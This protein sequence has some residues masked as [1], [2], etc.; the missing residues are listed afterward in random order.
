[1]CVIALAHVPRRSL[2][3]GSFDGRVPLGRIGGSRQRRR[4]YRPCT[5]V[6]ADHG[7]TGRMNVRE[8]TLDDAGAIRDVAQRSMEASYSL[9]PRTIQSAIKQW[10]ND[11]ALEETFGTDGVVFLVAEEDG[12]VVGF[13]E[14]VLDDTGNGDLLWLHVDPSVRGAGV[15]TQLFERMRTDLEER[16]AERLRG[17]VLEDNREGTDFFERFG[18]E[19]AEERRV[20][21]DGEPYVEFV[22]LEADARPDE[23][24]LDED[25]SVPK[26]VTTPDGR[27]VYLDREDPDRG[28]KGPF[29]VAYTDSDHE[30][31]YGFFCGNCESIDTAMDS[32]GRVQCNACGNLRKPTRWDAAYL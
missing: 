16:G 13:A 7:R 2:R 15:G 3:S 32:M 10:Y 11:D 23:A 31:R 8:A 9:S 17:M 6:Y 5:R 29:F 12:D 25:V 20:E 4:P 1:M 27:A 28:S 18:F 22:Y 26:E 30:D 21:I 24:P 19:K 14:S